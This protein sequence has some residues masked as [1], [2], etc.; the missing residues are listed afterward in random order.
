MICLFVAVHDQIKTHLAEEDGKVFEVIAR[1]LDF[2]EHQNLGKIVQDLRN[3]MSNEATFSQAPP[4]DTVT[5]SRYS[6]Q[7]D[8][9][10]WHSYFMFGSFVGDQVN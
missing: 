4:I 8:C 7:I 5:G 2:Q 9:A 10:H 1:F 6:A 3:Q